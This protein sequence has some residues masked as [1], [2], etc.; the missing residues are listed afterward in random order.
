MKKPRKK[1][2]QASVSCNGTQPPWTPFLLCEP[3]PR[4]REIQTYLNSRYQVHVRRY[5]ARDG[6]AGL[7]HLSIKRR[8]GQ[9][10]IPY[11]EQMRIKD[12]LCGPECEGVD[13]RPARSRE[14]DL[15]NQTHLWIIDEPIYLPFGFFDGRLVSDRTVPGATQEPWPPGERP[16]DCLSEEALRMLLR[17]QW[18]NRPAS[19]NKE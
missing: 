7:I 8:D 4:G 5:A 9:P 11:R 14:V 17:R 2:F 3:D 12:E 1:R 19:E 15:A 18:S 16:A 10:H 13:L 6:G